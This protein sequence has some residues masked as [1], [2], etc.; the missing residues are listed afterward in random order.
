M[1][2]TNI[3]LDEKLVAE[4]MRLTSKKTKKELV[5]YAMQ[6]LVSRLKRKKLLDLE[7]KVEWTG[8]LDEMR[9]GRV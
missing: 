6:E 7:G 5:N 1:L 2:R 4:A 8:S 9:K 3:E